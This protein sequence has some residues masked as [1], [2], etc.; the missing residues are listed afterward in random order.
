VAI[1]TIVARV[2][3]DDKRNFNAFCS[4]VG[5]NASIAV[6]LFIKTVLRE[7]RIPFNISGKSETSINLSEH[8]EA[9][10]D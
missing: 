7:N 10:H 9:N 1:S 3:A 8:E 4:S 2:D 5:L 6:N